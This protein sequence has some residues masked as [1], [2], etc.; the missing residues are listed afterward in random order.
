MA[1]LGRLVPRGGG[2]VIPLLHPKLTIGR[3]DSCDICLRFPNVSSFHCELTYRN[4][5]WIVEDNASK[6]G[7]KV[8]G[9]R[10]LKKLLHPG[11]LIA[12]A[13]HE[14]VID[15][16]LTAGKEAMDEMMD[17]VEGII[18]KPL[19]EKA[20]LMHPPEHPTPPAGIPRP[21]NPA[22]RPFHRPGDK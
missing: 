9:D 1:E 14:F 18:N 16:T 4:G 22:A 7:V 10:V 3:R 21:T 5:C 12:I 20:G 19:L 6:N 15:Y 2:D 13:K 8:N 17:E 11:D